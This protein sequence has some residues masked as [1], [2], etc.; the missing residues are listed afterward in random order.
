MRVA[1][2]PV[3]RGVG[4]IF[5]ASIHAG[6]LDSIVSTAHILYGQTERKCQN[7]NFKL[8]DV[9]DDVDHGFTPDAFN[10]NEVL[11]YAVDP[12]LADKLWTASEEMVGQK[13]TY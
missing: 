10:P 12:A 9:D 5:F 7:E 8:K 11:A 6:H 4:E 3:P 2:K 13:F 1:R